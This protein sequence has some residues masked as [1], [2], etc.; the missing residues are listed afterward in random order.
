MVREE[1]YL[2]LINNEYV[3]NGEID[4]DTLSAARMSEKI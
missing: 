4:W 2:V 1:V 3:R